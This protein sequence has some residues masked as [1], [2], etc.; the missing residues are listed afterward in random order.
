MTFGQKS[1]CQM[2]TQETCAPGNQN[3]HLN[4]SL[5]KL[6]TAQEVSLPCFF[7]GARSS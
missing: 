4:A 2:G 3:S 7:N 5:G 1:V 6:F